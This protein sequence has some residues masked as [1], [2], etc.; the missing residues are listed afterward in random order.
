MLRGGKEEDHVAFRSQALATISCQHRYQTIVAGCT[1]L[2]VF[3][4][5]GAVEG[6]A[7]PCQAF[8]EAV[9]RSRELEAPLAV[10][11]QCIARPKARTTKA[12]EDFQKGGHIGNS[13]KEHLLSSQPI[14][15]VF[16]GYTR[17]AMPFFEV[18]WVIY[19]KPVPNGGSPSSY[20][21]VFDPIH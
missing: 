13:S 5:V 9:Q 2:Q 11:H 6:T 8:A 4:Q 1:E 16:F 21:L 18:S 14:C 15:L 7:L 10:T 20:S 3:E 12:A 17:L 19:P